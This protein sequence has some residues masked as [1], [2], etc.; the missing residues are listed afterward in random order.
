MKKTDMKKFLPIIMFLGVPGVANADPISA[1]AFLADWGNPSQS[2]CNVSSVGDATIGKNKDKCRGS[3]SVSDMNNDRPKECLVVNKGKE[4]GSLGMMMLVARE[5]NANGARFCATTI[6]ATYPKNT[7]VRYAEPENGAFVCQWLCKP[8]Y[9][10][11]RCAQKDYSA[12]CDAELLKRDD[13][14]EY[15]MGSRPAVDDI[16]D[17]ISMF[18][19]GNYRKCGGSKGQKQNHNVILAVSGWLE[20]GHGAWVTPF[21]VRGNRG[22]HSKSSGSAEVWPAGA[23]ILLCKNGY[24]ANSTSDECVPVNAIVCATPKKTEAEIL[25][26]TKFCD[27]FVPAGYDSSIHTLHKKDGDTCT[28]YFCSEPGKAFPSVNNTSCVDCE[29]SIKGGANPQNGV[30][31]RCATGQY[32]DSNAGTCKSALAYSS[33]ELLYGKSNTKNKN[34]KVDNQC[35]PVVNPDE[36]AECVKSGGVTTPKKK[37][38]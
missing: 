29:S 19:W 34:P 33:V 22:K 9:G 37:D 1:K 25:A 32:F 38:E 31:V 18:S 8:G 10:G 36:Y 14:D 16:A 11:A 2:Y 13:F 7:Y 5:I 6:F 21:N 28:K 12:S 20:S 23:P 24:T 35:W 4:H 3:H 30:C 15:S 26:E 17:S 27:N